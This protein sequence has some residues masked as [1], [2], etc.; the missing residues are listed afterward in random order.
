MLDPAL[1]T[2]ILFAP[3]GSERLET[4]TFFFQFGK[5]VAAQIDRGAYS[6]DFRPVIFKLLR[7]MQ[8]FGRNCLIT[9]MDSSGSSPHGGN[10]DVETQYKDM[11][12]TCGRHYVK[13]E[14]ILNISDGKPVLF[15]PSLSEG[16]VDERSKLV[17]VLQPK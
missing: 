11:Y 5:L 15:D 1:T 12:I 4:G 13:M 8:A 3:H 17:E 10:Y 16:I 7:S 6:D 14:E 2:K 9:G